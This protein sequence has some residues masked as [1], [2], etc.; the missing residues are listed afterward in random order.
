LLFCQIKLAKM[1]LGTK[2]RSLRQLKG[3]SREQVAEKLKLSLTSY[4]NIERSETDL[5]F[6]RLTQI[7]ELFEVTPS[8]LLDLGEKMCIYANN[9]NNNS[10]CSSIG[11]GVVEITNDSKKFLIEIEKQKGEIHT[12]KAEVE[13]FKKEVAHLNKIVALLEGKVVR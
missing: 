7:A 13:G 4:A 3:L 6:S 9:S 1:T 2:I 11:I 8:Q 10:N 12:L 5:S